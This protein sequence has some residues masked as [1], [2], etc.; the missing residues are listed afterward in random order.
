MVLP[1]SDSEASL[2]L[3]NSDNSSVS[4]SKVST[5]SCVVL[6]VNNTVNNMAPIDSM[7]SPPQTVNN[8]LEPTR[9]KCH[10]PDFYYAIYHGDDPDDVKVEKL[11]KQNWVTD[12]LHDE[13]SRYYSKKEDV[14]RNH[15]TNDIFMNKDYFSLNFRKMFPAKRVFM[16]H[17][18][19]K[20]AVKIFFQH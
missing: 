3:N 7:V 5:K 15:L 6:H 11:R 17:I 16:N 9:L 14:T 20:Q 1:E 13:M 4:S 10:V 8:M 18:Q 19:L 12:S 2:K